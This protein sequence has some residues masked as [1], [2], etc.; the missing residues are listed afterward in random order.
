MSQPSCRQ[1]LLPRLLPCLVACAAGT[2]TVLRATPDGGAGDS[3]SREQRIVFLGDSITDGHTYPLL[4]AQ[5]LAAAH[6]PV[7]VCI[8]AGIG[9]DTAAGMRRRI[10]RDVLVRRP[11]LVTVSAGINDVLHKVKPADYEA[12]VRAIIRQVRAKDVPLILLTTSVLGPK[13]AEADR[14]LAEY[15]AILHR[16][17]QE[18]HYPVAEA[19]RLMQE[20]RGQGKQLLDDDQVHPNF[21]GHRLIARAVLDALGARDVPVPEKLKLEVMPGVV[22]DWK[23]RAAPKPDL[24]LDEQTVRD[25]QP[26]E[27]W[28]TVALPTKEPVAG[29]WREQERQRG[30]A[31]GLD[32]LVGP[33]RLY[34]GV[35]YLESEQP[36]D[37]FV[38]PAAEVQTVWL[39]GRRIYRSPDE[40]LGWHAGRARVPAR[41]WP[42]RNT[43]VVETGAN[44]FLSVTETNTW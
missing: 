23:L 31:M 5:A 18:Y 14:A 42:G 30:F 40:W 43:F 2:G 1:R 12:D 24:R 33:G 20:A 25:L 16:L 15:N 3:P 10:E 27:G 26:D 8:N 37:V 13:H 28:K 39:N 22:R 36:R 34:E 29:W 21:E 44:F 19:N 9:G 35:A 6:R 11:T 32:Q 38:N 41:L 7:P 4:V 17:A